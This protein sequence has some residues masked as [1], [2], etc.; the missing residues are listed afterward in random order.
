MIIC[1]LI[2]IRLKCS[3]TVYTDTEQRLCDDDEKKK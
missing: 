3:V 1:G 2:Y